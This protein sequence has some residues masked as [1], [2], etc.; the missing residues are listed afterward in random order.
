MIVKPFLATYV[1]VLSL[2]TVGTLALISGLY[3]TTDSHTTS[4]KA[5]RG[6]TAPRT[7]S[8]ATTPTRTAFVYLSG[9]ARTV[10]VVEPAKPSSARPVAHSARPTPTHT[11]APAT[12]PPATSR[13]P[14][15]PP[16][17]PSP[18]PSPT[19]QRGIDVSVHLGLNPSR[20]ASRPP[21]SPSGSPRA[22]A[23]SVLS[24]TQ[25]GCLDRVVSRESGWNIYAT[26]PSSGA[27]GLG[28]ALPGSKMASAGPDWRNNGVTQIRW[29]IRYM[30]GRYGSPCGAWGF[31]QSH[32]WY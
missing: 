22:Y 23:K 4:P 19:A 26:N 12:T 31:W 3:F 17:S 21:L 15:T 9:P 6:V 24:A 2:L 14:T 13:P 1:K 11:T 30:D 18:A 8:P 32:R 16:S 20:S 29:T 27:Y 10:T 5:D 25:Y 7:P 28:Q